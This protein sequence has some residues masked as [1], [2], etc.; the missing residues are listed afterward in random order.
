MNLLQTKENTKKWERRNCYRNQS[1][2]KN[3]EQKNTGKLPFFSPAR[4]W[5]R[6]PPTHALPVKHAMTAKSSEKHTSHLTNNAPWLSPSINAVI[7]FVKTKE[8]PQHHNRRRHLSVTTSGICGDAGGHGR[9]PAHCGACTSQA[10]KS[11]MS[12]PWPRRTWFSFSKRTYYKNKR[13]LYLHDLTSKLSTFLI[14]N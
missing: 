13:V 2:T 8:D 7:K 9:R 4:N 14:L 11:R 1:N 6:Q 10:T 12:L 5:G 3:P